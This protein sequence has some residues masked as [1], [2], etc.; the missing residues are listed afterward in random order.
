[1]HQIYD[2]GYK[3]LFKNKSIFRQLLETFVPEAWIKELDFNTC[4]T[5][6]GVSHSSV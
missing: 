1:M 2:K 6:D 5:L 3:K 4:E